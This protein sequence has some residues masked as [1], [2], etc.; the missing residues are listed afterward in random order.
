MDV[1]SCIEIQFSEYLAVQRN[2]KVV[3]LFLFVL[4]NEISVEW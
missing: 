1:T 2:Q 4:L 3:Y